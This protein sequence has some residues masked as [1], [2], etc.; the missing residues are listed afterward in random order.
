MPHSDPRTL[1]STDWLAKHQHSPDIRI[2]DATWFLPTED[3]DPKAEYNA[4]H[5]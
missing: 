4:C 1:V 2:I 5:I 3:R